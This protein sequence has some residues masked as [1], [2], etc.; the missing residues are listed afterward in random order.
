[1]AQ[2]DGL[3]RAFDSDPLDQKCPKCD[4]AQPL[5][6]DNHSANPLW[7]YQLLPPVSDFASADLDDDG[8]VELLCGAR[9]GLYAL[10]EVAGACSVAWSKTLGRAVGSP[11]LA[12]LDNNGRAEILVSTE[13]G[14]LHCLGGY[15]YIADLN[16]DGNVNVSDLAILAQYWLWQ[17]D[18]E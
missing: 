7:Q 9:D 12:D 14:Y 18:Q 1:M 10:E 2:Q 3:L 5:T 13:D 4:P 16:G 17:G 6:A 11:I 15:G 8:K